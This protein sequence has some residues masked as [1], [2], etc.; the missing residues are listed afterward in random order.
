MI[1]CAA[2]WSFNGWTTEGRA[3]RHRIKIEGYERTGPKVDKE[4]IDRGAP[5]QSADDK[6][7]E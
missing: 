2:G 5:P 6:T 1:R 3:V 4:R 7:H